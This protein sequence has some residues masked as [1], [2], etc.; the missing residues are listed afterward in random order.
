MVESYIEREDKFDVPPAW[1]LPDLG[2][3][4]PDGAV[5][6]LSTL[7]LTS[8][9]FD[10]DDRAL[11]AFGATLRRRSGDADTGWHLKLPA[12]AARRELKLP[13]S[14][15]RVRVPKKLSTLV[16]GISRG[17]ELRPLATL[18][19]VRTTYRW[20]DADGVQLV[21]IA[22]DWV[23]AVAPGPHAADLAEWRE[24]EAELG[25]AGDEKLLAAVGRVLL[26]AGARRSNSA[27]KVARALGS[28]VNPTKG[29]RARPTAGDVLL[30]YLAE[31][32]AQLIVGDVAL[33]TGGDAVH[34]TRVALRRARS[35]LRV[36]D[37]LVDDERAARLDDE[38]AWYADV[39][40]QVRDCQVQ[41]RRFDDALA[42]LP[43]EAV[44]GPVHARIEQHLLG[45]EVVARTELDAVL[46]GPRYL[47]LL[48][49]VG[50]WLSE[51]PLTAAAQDPP[52]TLLKPAIKARRKA[53]NRLAAG[54]A[55]TDEALLHRARKAAK[56]ARYA[57]EL[58]RAGLGSTKL[59]NAKA[60]KQDKKIQDI[61]GAHQDAMVAA[62]LLRRLGAGTAD[63]P[64]EN[65]FTYGLLYHREL[66]IAADSRRQADRWQR[67]H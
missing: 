25:P 61:L 34:E 42:E 6:A 31:Q 48:R 66:D 35:V 62:D 47:A 54:L 32:D 43:V 36:F 17:R 10:T 55:S 37:K 46:D 57:A 58:I 27:N 15:A 24:V 9:Y 13:L 18:H 41:R 44:L 22:D 11:L 3:A 20:V 59:T 19:T 5:V 12:G 7:D 40:G 30:R 8:E 38:L 65:G 28:T 29:K 45:R 23:R 64:G 4:L 56:R 16:T 60:R 63:L 67:K 52:A 39:L 53:T 51:P 1:V 26:D 50:V 33:R 49:D 2:K 21:E 14:A